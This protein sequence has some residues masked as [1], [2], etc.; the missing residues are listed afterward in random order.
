MLRHVAFGFLALGLVCTEMQGGFAQEKTGKAL[1]KGGLTMETRPILATPPG[2]KTA[3]R[4]TRVCHDA[5]PLG[6][7]GPPKILCELKTVCDGDAPPPL[8]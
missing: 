1:P 4:P 5:R 7:F 3:C 2:L 8:H 6:D